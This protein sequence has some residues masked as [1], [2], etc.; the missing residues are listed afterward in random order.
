VT[1]GEHKWFVF[2][3]LDPE[4]RNNLIKIELKIW[5]KKSEEFHGNQKREEHEELGSGDDG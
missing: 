5:R 3:A 1:G 4:T 2:N